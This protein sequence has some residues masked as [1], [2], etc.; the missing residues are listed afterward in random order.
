MTVFEAIRDL[1]GEGLVLR[2]KRVNRLET[3]F[4]E[5]KALPPDRLERAADYIHRLQTV[6]QTERNAILRSTAGI[7]SGAR[8]E[9]FA[10]NIQEGF[11]QV[12][13]RDW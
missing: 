6:D 1:P 4:E 2:S 8:G 11:G 3:I 12:D 10:R 7:M 9:E 5:L 13:E